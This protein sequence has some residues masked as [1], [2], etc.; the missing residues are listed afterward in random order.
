[1]I[2]REQT[3]E[4]RNV[5]EA[6]ETVAEQQR[7]NPTQQK[8]NGQDERCSD[9]RRHG[10]HACVLYADVLRGGAVLWHARK[11]AGRRDRGGKTSFAARRRS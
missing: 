2:A 8:R 4:T 10:L 5:E 11:Q 9:R 3:N 6:R 1:M 7:T